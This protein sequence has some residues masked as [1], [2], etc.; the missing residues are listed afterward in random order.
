M[1]G[2]PTFKKIFLAVQL[3]LLGGPDRARRPPIADPWYIMIY[4]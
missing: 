2:K 3:F 4:I 1:C